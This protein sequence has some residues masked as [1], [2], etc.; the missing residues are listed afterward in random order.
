M[1]RDLG[2]GFDVGARRVCSARVEAAIRLGV[3]SGGDDAA[4]RPAVAQGRDRVDGAAG[5]PDHH[6]RVDAPDAGP[7]ERF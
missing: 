5:A 6:D 1:R 2:W 3:G 4:D 7:A